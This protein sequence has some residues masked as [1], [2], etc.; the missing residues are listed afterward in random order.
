MDGK[1]WQLL[2]WRGRAFASDPEGAMFARLFRHLLFWYTSLLMVLVIL[3]GLSIGSTVPWL[4]MV[5]SERGLSG[6]I[7]HFAQNWQTAS[8]EVCPLAIP[9]QGYML[10]CYD[11]QGNVLR[12]FGVKKGVEEHFLDNALALNAL[13]EGTTV[14]D[15][16]DETGKEQVRFDF[17]FLATARPG[18]IRQA[19]VVRKPGTNLLLGVLQLGTTP[20]ETLARRGTI[21]NIFFLCMFFAVLFGTPAGGWYLARK[22]LQPTR[23]AFQRQKDF[24][25][26]VSHEL[27][28]PLALL[29]ANADV[30]L[31]GR[32][33]LAEEDVTLIED[34]VTETT[35]MDKLIDNMLLLARMDAGHLLL[36][37][38]ELNLAQI[39]EKEVGRMQPL[40]EQAQVTLVFQPEESVRVQGDRMLLGQVTLILLNNALKYTQP[41]GRVSVYT[42]KEKDCACLR[43]SDT[44]IGIAP[45]ELAR[46][47]TRFYRVDKAR[48]RETGG[49]GLGLSIAY[50]ILSA[51]GGELTLT[52]NPGKGTT[53]TIIL[54]LAHK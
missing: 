54:P 53:A 22:A 11:A 52:S 8:G 5:S 14:S 27:G 3:L 23:Q 45:A 30:L 4:V 39:A 33:R 34:I 46:L 21:V 50:G 31:L 26:N 38:E 41:G 9:G 36:E 1:R 51:H 12:S 16:L 19:M 29:R 20:A 43:V 40:A 15:A 10:A 17:V 48:S 2:P 49:N 35:Y 6:K 28:T 32:A 47:G 13:K 44:G 25:A 7:E 18:M 24:I 42:F 37:R